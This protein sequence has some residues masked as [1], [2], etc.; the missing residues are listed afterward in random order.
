MSDDALKV[1]I[2]KTAD[3]IAALAVADTLAG[4][5]MIWVNKDGGWEY[6]SM[7]D[8]SDIET[9]GLLEVAKSDILH[10]AAE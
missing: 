4:A 5:V 8:L 3:L 7:G 1:E 10:H 6:Q 9:V 2:T